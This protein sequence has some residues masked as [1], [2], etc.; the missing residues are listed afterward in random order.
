MDPHQQKI[1]EAAR[2]LGIAVEELAGNWHMDVVR[3]SWQ[4]TSTFVSE[5]RIF[6]HLSALADQVVANKMAAK[7][8]MTELGIPV[9]AGMVLRRDQL[10][11]AALT[12][13]L[14]EHEPAVLKPLFGSDGFAIVMHVRLTEQVLLHLQAFPTAGE[15]WLLEE[16][17][18]GEDLRLQYL[19]GTLI[20]ACI[21]KPCTLR[22]DGQHSVGQLIDLRNALI[23]TQN[24]DNHIEVDHQVRRRVAHA[25]LG[26][27]DILPKGQELQIK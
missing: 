16:Q 19:G 13:W 15:V 22:G 2:R 25:G 10:D 9:P 7:A 12:A 3:L 27:D 6:T 4:G 1:I 26:L 18:Q 23:H 24:P 14:D 5:G 20:A 17:A 11:K 8:L 21:R